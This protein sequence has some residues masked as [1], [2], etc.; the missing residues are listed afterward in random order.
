MANEH[1]SHHST[2]WSSNV[3]FYRKCQKLIND[4]RNFWMIGILLKYSAFPWLNISSF[5]MLLRANLN[6]TRLRCTNKM[7]PDKTSTISASR[8]SGRDVPFRHRG[9]IHQL[10]LSK[11]W[12]QEKGQ[13]LS[14]IRSLYSAFWLSIVLLCGINSD[15][16]EK[17][18][19]FV[20]IWEGL[21]WGLA[22]FLIVFLGYGDEI[23]HPR[24]LVVCG[25][26]VIV[27]ALSTLSWHGF[28]S[29]F[30]YIYY[31]VFLL[32][33]KGWS[34]IGSN[35]KFADGCFREKKRN[36]LMVFQKL[37][38]PYIKFYYQL[39]PQRSWTLTLKW[40]ISISLNCAF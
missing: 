10:S 18:Q 28:M 11:M 23:M 34:G 21:L 30:K 16:E 1:N 13:A 31:H 3:K 7:E 8:S 19:S 22:G 12:Q 6:R 25:D 33:I 9:G 38:R 39:K 37:C 29:E 26:G 4:N 15:E 27:G 2:A 14:S 36:K 20:T 24:T 40:T 5:G 32:L 17:S 35:L